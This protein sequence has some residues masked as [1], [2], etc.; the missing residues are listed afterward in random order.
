MA[1]L[2]VAAAAPVM[3]ARSDLHVVPLNY[4]LNPQPMAVEVTVA[5]TTRW[6]SMPAAAGHQ[7]A[8]AA[9]SAAGRAAAWLLMAMGLVV[10][11]MLA[12]AL[13]APVALGLEV[14]A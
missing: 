9:A 8:M 3:A 11:A 7:A 4:L 5:T 10:V 6:Q 13:V 2:G 14:V 1:V 12:V